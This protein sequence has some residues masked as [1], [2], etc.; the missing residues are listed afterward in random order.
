MMRSFLEKKKLW[1]VIYVCAWVIRACTGLLGGFL[2]NDTVGL[3][4]ILIL[5]LVV[6]GGYLLY[7]LLYLYIEVAEAAKWRRFAVMG[8]VLWVAYFV[9]RDS[10]NPIGHSLIGIL[11]AVGGVMLASC[12]WHDYRLIT[13]KEH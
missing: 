13:G 6:E 10:L 1:L 2:G 7:R 12:L 9:F 3:S 8:C 4:V 11:G 5:C